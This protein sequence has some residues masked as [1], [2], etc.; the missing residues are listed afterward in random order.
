ML[1][2]KQNWRAVISVADHCAVVLSPLQDKVYLFRSVEYSSSPDSLC[3]H[4]QAHHPNPGQRKTFKDPKY[5]KGACAWPC[6]AE[7]KNSTQ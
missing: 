1:K 6:D 4:T 2:Q 7:I 5:N 3:R